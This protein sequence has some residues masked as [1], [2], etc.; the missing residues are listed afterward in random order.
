MMV[1]LK[2]VEGNIEYTCTLEQWIAVIDLAKKN[3]WKPKGTYIDFE[4]EFDMVSGTN[5]MFCDR[6]YTSLWV[7]NYQINWDGNYTEQAGQFVTREDADELRYF[8]EDTGVDDELLDFLS[9]GGFQIL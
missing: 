1:R 3:R 7:H 9:E 4:Y 5:L 6:L 8:L 2:S